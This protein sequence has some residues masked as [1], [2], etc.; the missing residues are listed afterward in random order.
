MAIIRLVYNLSM[1]E[2]SPHPR[3]QE[4]PELTEAQAALNEDLART[5]KLNDEIQAFLHPEN[6][7]TEGGLALETARKDFATRVGVEVDEKIHPLDQIIQ[8]G[9]EVAL[10]LAHL[11]RRAA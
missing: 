11:K 4:L 6:G 1:N 2:Q 5:Q 7:S 8:L 10:E 3:T 9:N